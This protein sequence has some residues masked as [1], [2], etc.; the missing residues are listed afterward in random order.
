MLIT[1]KQNLGAAPWRRKFSRLNVSF[2]VGFT[3]VMV[4]PWN[5]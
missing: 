2:I 1:C 3:F 4:H 5:V